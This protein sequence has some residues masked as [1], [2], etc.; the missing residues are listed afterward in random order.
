MQI[1]GISWASQLLTLL[2]SRILTAPLTSC[3]LKNQDI[4]RKLF[5]NQILPTSVE[6]LF[7]LLYKQM[8]QLLAHLRCHVPI[9]LLPTALPGS[10]DIVRCPA[11]QLGPESSAFTS[12][13]R[14]GPCCSAFPVQ[15]NRCFACFVLPRVSVSSVS[16]QH[17]GQVLGDLANNWLRMSC[18]ALT[19]CC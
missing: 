1:N 5:A 10:R 16:P 13:L 19:P 6:S 4:F 18:E 12:P 11:W 15:G 9:H 14:A 3:P 7:A 17:A 8:L 2:K